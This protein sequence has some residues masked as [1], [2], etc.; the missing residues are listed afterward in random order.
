MRKFAFFD[1]QGTCTGIVE[2]KS[3]P[4]EDCIEVFDANRP[5]DIWFDGE[6]VCQR[7]D[8]PETIPD[9]FSVG[10]VITAPIEGTLLINGEPVVGSYEVTNAGPAWLQ[11]KGRYRLSKPVNFVTYYE[12]RA[13]AYPTIQD[14]LDT[15]YHE[16][17]DVWREQIDEVKAAYPKPS[18]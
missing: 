5:D 1:E 13:S 18:E 12:E 6:R 8:Y 16:G 7:E 2:F 14:Q 10:E 4:S 17:L 9:Q 11:I 15:I 3:P